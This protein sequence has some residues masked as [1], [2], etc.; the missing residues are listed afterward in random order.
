MFGLLDAFK[1]LG[2]QVVGT[3]EHVTGSR[4]STL[5]WGVQ[6]PVDELEKIRRKTEYA[7]IGCASDG[8]AGDPAFAPV[9]TGV[10]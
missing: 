9:D 3:L 2:R 5:E 10:E 6:E 1:D 7:A 8:Q 4:S